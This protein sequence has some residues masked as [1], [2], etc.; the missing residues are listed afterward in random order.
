MLF[1]ALL[2]T[3]YYLKENPSKYTSLGFC[4]ALGAL[5]KWMTY[6]LLIPYIIYDVFILKKSPSGIIKTCLI[7]L[8]G[9]LPSL[10]WNIEHSFAT[11]RHVGGTILN[12]HT[13]HASPNPISFL[14]AGIAL[15]SPG[16]FL[17]ALPNIFSKRRDASQLLRLFVWVIWGGLLL[18]SC[19]R[20]VQ[21]NWAVLGQIMIFPLLGYSLTLEAFTKASLYKKS[22][23]ISIFVSL[24]LQLV[25]LAAP[26][27]KGT[28]LTK[29]PLR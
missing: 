25:F 9:L 2:G 15:L 18:L 12:T 21:G 3:Y 11:F 14:L 29:S 6:S 20:K 22:F 26:Y 1:W 19:F 13:A 28:F 7:S 27:V 24:F 17:L 10:I 23:S 16:F 8:L 5:W 4:I